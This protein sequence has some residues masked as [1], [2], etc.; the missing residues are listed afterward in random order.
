M[1][2]LQMCVT[3]KKLSTLVDLRILPICRIII[4]INI[5]SLLKEKHICHI[6]TASAELPVL[7]FAGLLSQLFTCTLFPRVCA[8]DSF[9]VLLT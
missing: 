6:C 7:W 9:I 8:C 5:H 4:E 3:I 2:V 1:I